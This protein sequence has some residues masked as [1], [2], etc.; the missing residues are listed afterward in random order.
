M[1]N[2]MGML[3][4]IVVLAILSP[5]IILLLIHILSKNRQKRRGILERI[6]SYAM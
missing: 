5:I 6:K 3:I 4:T 2:Q 1:D